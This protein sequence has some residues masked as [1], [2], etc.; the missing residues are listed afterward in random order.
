MPSLTLNMPEVTKIALKKYQKSIFD[1][2]VVQ[3]T[4]KIIV[5]DQIIFGFP[6]LIV[7]SSALVFLEQYTSC[8]FCSAMLCA[9]FSFFSKTN[10]LAKIFRLQLIGQNY[11]LPISLEQI[12]GPD[13]TAEFR[14]LVSVTNFKKMEK[15]CVKC[16]F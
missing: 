9:E 15:K 13:T 14:L 5:L 4:Y 3:N 12:F 8:M 6:K 2:F 1:W 11:I 16:S 10:S 7:E